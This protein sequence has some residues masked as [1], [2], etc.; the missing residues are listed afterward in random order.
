M[1]RGRWREATGGRGR[2]GAGPHHRRL[3]WAHLLPPPPASSS[4]AAGDLGSV[5]N[6]K[7]DQ[8]LGEPLAVGIG[9]QILA[10][11]AQH[12]P[13]VRTG[14][15]VGP[16]ALGPLSLW[17]S[18]PDTLSRAPRALQSCP[19]RP[20]HSP[21]GPKPPAHPPPAICPFLEGFPH[22]LSHLEPRAS[23]GSLSQS[24]QHLRGPPGSPQAHLTPSRAR[25]FP[26]KAAVK[27]LA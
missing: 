21:R 4:E 3:L 5:C 27:K 20:A 8:A 17:M 9:A 13:G 16:M 26:R 23:A 19:P 15:C 14:G 10:G 22:W 1:G 6:T 2:G 7:G 11:C 12:Q 18:S 25:E 24:L